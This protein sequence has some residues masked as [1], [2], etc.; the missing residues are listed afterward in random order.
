MPATKASGWEI[1]YDTIGDRGA[2]PIVMVLGLSHRRPHWGRLP[3]LLAERLFVVTFDCRNIGE[4]ERRDEPYTIADETRDV[5][6]VMDAAGLEAA[7]IYGRSRGGMI[8]QEF[9]IGQP[10]RTAALILSGTSHRGPG[11]VGEAPHVARAMRIEPGMGREDIFA[12][13]NVAM[14][15]PGWREREPA[16]FAYCL[17]VDLEAPPRRFAVERQR[18][19]LTGWSSFDRLGQIA[20]PTLVLCGEDDPM[21]PP[22]N[23]RSLA[24]KIP[25]AKLVLIPQCGHLPM[26][27]QPEAVRDAVFTFLG[28][29]AS[30]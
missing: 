13:Q 1:A 15:S 18:E 6:A 21:V 29:Q 20:A 23:S 3:A 30:G 7:A 26:L 14:A 5:A 22:E 12:S 11:S 17:S 19:A 27:E 25:G 2:P 28:S 4:S 24:A 9:A 16:A 10:A 8:A